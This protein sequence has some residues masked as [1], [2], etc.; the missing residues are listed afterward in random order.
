MKFVYKILTCKVIGNYSCLINIVELR[1]QMV[2]SKILRY[3]TGNRSGLVFLEWQWHLKWGRMGDLAGCIIGTALNNLFRKK[4]NINKRSKGHNKRQSF[5]TGCCWACLNVSSPSTGFLRYFLGKPLC[6]EMWPVALTSSHQT[7]LWRQALCRGKTQMA[8]QSLAMTELQ[9]GEWGKVCSKWHH[10]HSGSTTERRGEEGNTRP[11][12]TSGKK[13]SFNRRRQ[14]QGKQKQRNNASLIYTPWTNTKGNIRYCISNHEASG[15]MF[16]NTT[17]VIRRT[18][19][20]A[21]FSC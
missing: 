16:H 12:K 2:I 4:K 21:W 15:T 13:T 14:N 5:E 19:R 6:G 1:K 18:E 10:T 3:T 20:W 8:V 11:A 9:T 17:P 7:R